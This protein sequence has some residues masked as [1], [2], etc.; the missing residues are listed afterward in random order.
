MRKIT[1]LFTAVCGMPTCATIDSLRAGR[2]ADYTVIGVDCSPND[3]ALN[4]VDFLYKVPRCK[5]S[6]YIS[7]ILEIC[8]SH[9]VDVLVPLISDEINVLWE[10]M[11]DFKCIGTRLLLS[12]K[13]SLLHIANDKLELKRFLE[14]SGIDIMPKTYVYDERTV[15]DSLAALGYPDKPVAFKLKDIV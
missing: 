11:D 15:D 6:G 3:S 9:G 14:K 8:R 12:G 1:V 10:H 2:M 4:Y 13:D 5:D 7:S